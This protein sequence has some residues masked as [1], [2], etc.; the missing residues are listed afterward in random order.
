MTAIGLHV[1]LATEMTGRT[2]EKDLKSSIVRVCSLTSMLL[3]I[4]A[5]VEEDFIITL[6]EL[7][8]MSHQN[9]KFE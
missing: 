6:H 4:G 2:Q 5:F 1:V 9:S 3:C 8:H 7:N